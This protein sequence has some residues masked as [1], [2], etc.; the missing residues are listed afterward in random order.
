M[1][2]FNHPKV[3]RLSN[4]MK[5]AVKCTEYTF[6]SCTYLHFHCQALAELQ[7]CFS[8]LVNRQNIA[9]LN[10]CNETTVSGVLQLITFIVYRN[11][12]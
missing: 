1:L 9:C 8:V 11:I 5:Q 10:L 4:L 12:T 7:I 2:L 3:V 6:S